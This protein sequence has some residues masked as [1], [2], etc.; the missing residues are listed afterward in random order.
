[1]GFGCRMM[2]YYENFLTDPYYNLAL[3]EYIFTHE[4]LGKSFVMLWQNK[5]TIVIG[6]NQNP[7]KEINTDDVRKLNTKIL[8]RITGGGSVFHDMGNINYS[9]ISN[10]EKGEEIDFSQ[11]AAP[12]LETLDQFGVKAECNQ[13][14]DLVIEGKKIS[15]TA[16][17]VRNGRLLHHGT[18]LF[19]SDLSL[20]QRILTCKDDKI[21]AKGVKSVPSTV[22]NISYHLPKKVSLEVFKKQLLKNLIKDKESEA[23]QL[24]PNDTKKINELRETK[25][26]TW[27]WNYGKTPRFEV[28]KKR[29]YRG[30]TINL[31]I[32]ASP[33][34]MIDSINLK[35]NFPD[36]KK[37]VQL[38]KFL[39]G[40][41]LKES[42]LK[43]TLS[44]IDLNEF[45]PAML[46]SEMLD[47]ILY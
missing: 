43:E 42:S 27:E 1:M 19:D 37:I 30:G 35:G 12:I 2:I 44:Y 21:Q 17:T 11:F 41:L 34:G 39:E 14:K 25:Y 29:S 47:F 36:Q 33:K 40:N 26:A 4:K 32:K 6:R 5:N 9:F 8:R 46:A 24:I 22:T 10:C 23:L 13:R 38:E 7:F 15:G 20:V 3:E 31:S 45:I 18:L 28:E 16:Q